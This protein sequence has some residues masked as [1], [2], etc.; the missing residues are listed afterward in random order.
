MRVVETGDMSANV[1]VS[2]VP[3]FLQG[4]VAFM[5]DRDY[6]GDWEIEFPALRSERDFFFPTAWEVA[7]LHQ[8][9][10]AFPW[11]TFH[12]I[13]IGLEEQNNVTWS[14]QDGPFDEVL[15]QL[16]RV[17]GNCGGS[18]AT[19]DLM[20]D[21]VAPDGTAG[22]AIFPEA[23]RLTLSLSHPHPVTGWL[24]IWPNVFTDE[25]YIYENGSD[26][27]IT[28]RPI[29]FAPAA[30]TNRIRLATSLHEWERLSNGRIILWESERVET[31][32]ERYGFAEDAQPF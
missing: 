19:L 5:R 23:A 4:L 24:T 21:W 2:T 28:R 12:T 31:G 27:S 6:V 9:S 8:F 14:Q 17:P 7:L 16:S 26:S 3:P 29:P 11:A 30:R 18:V 1:D 20:L 10:T 32:I 15:A 13:E 22:Q 25:I